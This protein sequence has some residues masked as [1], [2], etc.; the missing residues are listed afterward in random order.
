MIKC[1]ICIYVCKMFVDVCITFV[2]RF[3]MADE[4]QVNINTDVPI[5]VRISPQL[6]SEIEASVISTG[7]KKSDVI[8]LSISRGLEILIGQLS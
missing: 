6:N 7:L 3:D 5:T 1:K 2:L 4:E 8:R